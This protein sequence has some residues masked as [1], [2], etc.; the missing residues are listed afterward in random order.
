MKFRRK[1][2]QMYFTET[3]HLQSIEAMMKTIPHLP[4]AE[5]TAEQGARKTKLR[6]SSKAHYD[7]FMGF[8][9][10]RRT[11]PLC[12]EPEFCAAIYLMTAD[13]ELWN[14]VKSAVTD[15]NINFRRIKLGVVAADN[16]ALYKTAKDIF[17]NKQGLT[18]CELR[19]M[20]FDHECMVDLILVAY[21]VAKDGFGYIEND[22]FGFS[23]KAS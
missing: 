17:Y 4:Q 12:C 2:Y 21:R 15:E 18:P 7:R 22:K 23:D 20:L 8:F 14:K 1:E 11:N 9:K 13:P 16:Y 5:T 10:S 19:S 6:F 3:P